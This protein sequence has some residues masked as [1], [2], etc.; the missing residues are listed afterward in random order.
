M[1]QHVDEYIRLSQFH[2]ESL[3]DSSASRL[4]DFFMMSPAIS[5]TPWPVSV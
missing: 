2:A 5:T 4:S 3:S 1:A